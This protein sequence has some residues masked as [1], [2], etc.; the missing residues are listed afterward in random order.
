MTIDTTDDV[1][2]DLE[3]SPEKGSTGSPSRDLD[4]SEQVLGAGA[5]T[6]MLVGLFADGL[7]HQEQ[8][9]DSFFTPWHALLYTGFLAAVGQFAFQVRRRHQPGAPWR[10]AIPAELEYVPAGIVAFGIGGGADLLWHELLGIEVGIGALLS[11][12]HLLLLCGGVALLTGPLRRA[13]QT[14]ATAPTLRELGPTLAGVSAVMAIGMFFTSFASPFTRSPADFP[15]VAADVHDISEMTP[16]AF[17]QLRELWGVS[18]I[19]VTTLVL[20]LPV[21]ALLRRFRLPAGALTVVGVVFAIFESALGSFER[22][23]LI[24]VGLVAGGVGDILIHRLRP[25]VAVPSM[26]LALWTTYFAVSAVVHD[27]RWDAE[28][29][30]GSI[31]IA[32]LV[33]IAVIAVTGSDASRRDPVATP[34]T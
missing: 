26:V 9:P 21:L 6:W 16:D 13:W 18:A 29:W 17:G 15:S 30:S 27:V 23:A 32:T 31:V 12:T 1:A 24:A 3:A 14:M 2:A 28:L 5:A 25:I 8:K 33:S 11:P 34:D 20:V 10:N 19:L 22:P 7:A 4:R